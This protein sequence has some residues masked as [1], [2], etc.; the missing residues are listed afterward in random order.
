MDTTYSTA[1]TDLVLF[2]GLCKMQINTLLQKFELFALSD[3]GF[4]EKGTFVVEA[5]ND[6]C[7]SLFWSFLSS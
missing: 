1:E 5:T 3:S 4:I 7:C 2:Y 6:V